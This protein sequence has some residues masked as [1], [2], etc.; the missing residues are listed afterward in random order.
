MHD[1]PDG[2][3]DVQ[4][5]RSAAFVTS[6]EASQFAT[7]KGKEQVGW[8]KSDTSKVWAYQ[9]QTNK[10][11]VNSHTSAKKMDAPGQVPGLKMPSKH[12]DAVHPTLPE[13]TVFVHDPPD[14]RADVQSPVS[15][16]LGK[17]SDASQFSGQREPTT[18][19]ATWQEPT[20]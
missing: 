2:R 6:S 1:P 12:V 20:K 7:L 10:L 5:P 19:E 17:S 11:K 16:A 13:N 3:A 14:G 9:K 4:S 15:A 8:G 18:T